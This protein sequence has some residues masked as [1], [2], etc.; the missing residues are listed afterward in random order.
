MSEGPTD[1]ELLEMSEH[2]T[3]VMADKFNRLAQQLRD[4]SIIADGQKMEFD[5]RVQALHYAINFMR[6]SSNINAVNHASVLGVADQFYEWLKT[7]NKP[8]LVEECLETAK[9]A[10]TQLE[11]AF[12][13]E[14][15]EEAKRRAAENG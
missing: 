7:G 12:P 5:Y 1:R 3:A 6:G 15:I 4:V 8:D 13:A 2:N 14:V 11:G 9:F 10:W